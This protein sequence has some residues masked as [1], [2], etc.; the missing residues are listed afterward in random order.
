MRHTRGVSGGANVGF[1]TL[2]LPSP[3]LVSSSTG[4]LWSPTLQDQPAHP[5]G[6]AAP[7]A[8]TDRTAAT[9]ELQRTMRSL[10]RRRRGCDAAAT[11]LL[12]A[13]T[14]ALVLHSVHTHAARVVHMMPGARTGCAAC[15]APT[16]AVCVRAEHTA[17]DI[18]AAAAAGVPP[19]QTTPPR[20]SQPTRMT[21]ST[22]LLCLLTVSECCTV[23][24]A[25]SHSLRAAR[26]TRYPTTHST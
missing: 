5:L 1:C 14:W 2:L 18:T 8:A 17:A 25:A 22:S 21:R 10:R 20:L 11:A 15:A 19:L 6:A 13:C 7:T 12:T 3:L 26:H 23:A 24:K 4:T 9:R 16:C